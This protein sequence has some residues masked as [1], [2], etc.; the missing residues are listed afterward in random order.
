MTEKIHYKFGRISLVLFA[1]IVI[2]AGCGCAKQRTWT[3]NGVN[4]EDFDGFC[5]M[6]S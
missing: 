3:K 5:Q 4:Q 2:V 1:M 6:Y